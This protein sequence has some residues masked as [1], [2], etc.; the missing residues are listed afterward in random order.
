[1]RFLRNGSLALLLIS[2]LIGCGGEEDRVTET[3]NSP[4]PAPIVEP[5]APPPA[6]PPSGEPAPPAPVALECGAEGYP[7]SLN[8]VSIE[9]LNRGEALADSVIAMLDAGSSTDEALNYLRS[10]TDVA[11]AAGNNAALRFRLVGG[12]DVFIFQPEALP[13]VAPAGGS[14]PA[15]ASIPV[16][17]PARVAVPTVDAGA[18]KMTAHRVVVGNGAEQKRAL[19][20]SPFKYFFQGF[21]DGAPVAQLLENTRG[22]GGNVT[23]LENATKTAA[24]VGI[25]QFSG[26]DN[27]DVIHVTGHGA[28]VC[29]V[30]RCVT[31]ILTGDIYSN[32]DDLLQ[33]TELGVNT[34][35]VVGSERKFL[36]LSPDFFRKQYPAGLDSKLVFFNGCQT[37]SESDSALSDALLGPNSVF[38]GWTDVVQSQAG[39]DAALALFQ[40]LSANG[41][42]AQ[43]AFDSLG[44]L[45]LNRHTFEGK[46]IEARLMMDHDVSG[47]LRIREVV[48]L[49][50]TTGGGELLANATVN[51]VGKANDGVIDLVPYQILVE[52]IHE[53]EQDAAVIRFTVDGHSS[54]PQAVSAG[55]RVGDTG[56]R[57][58]GQIPY[59]DVATEQTVEMLAT[60]QLP[61]GGTSE[62][63]VSVN[64]K[65]GEDP[66]AKDAEV[67][68]GQGVMHLDTDTSFNQVHVTVVANVTFKQDPSTIGSRY[69]YLYSTGGTLTWSRSGAVPTAFD[70]MCSYSAGPVEIAIPDGDGDIIID[71]AATPHTYTMGGLT[72]GPEI[73]VAENCGLYAFSTRVG[74]SWAP[75]IV[76][77]D[78]LTVSADGG[79]ISGTKSSSNSSWEWTFRRQ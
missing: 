6:V 62:H 3:G 21:D 69:K 72:R 41:V 50:R 71:T 1:M 23:Y 78:L 42:T 35:H 19:V 5:P 29:D 24:T 59:I 67:W 18:R 45:T 52:G 30:N 40:N 34:A 64:L 26:W 60:V 17:A 68:I 66:Q 15:P 20:L 10:Q 9:V 54:T 56:W 75:V 14:A 16:P 49:E 57:L 76:R 61:E 32:A 28:Q 13:S 38:F 51:V 53:S 63:R 8:E 65:A 44:D 12:R 74:G 22:Y 7:C 31:T 58:T 48:K 70:G 25:E 77:A 27:Y 37:Y 39:K 11:D 33:L 2:T 46:E 4:P 43:S 73:R 55:E 47:E 79:T 36:A